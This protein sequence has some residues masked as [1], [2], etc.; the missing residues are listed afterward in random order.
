MRNT[1]LKRSVEILNSFPELQD[2]FSSAEKQLKSPGCTSCRRRKIER[3][4]IQKLSDLI[5]R[6]SE[7]QRREIFSK[8]PF[9]EALLKKAPESPKPPNTSKY[10][11]EDNTR[12]SCLE[13]VLKHTAQAYVLMKES[14]QGYV[15]HVEKADQHL[16]KALR[17]VE[18]SRKGKLEE[19]RNLL[20][21]SL[22]G[23]SPCIWHL[24]RAEGLLLA[25]AQ[26]NFPE[27]SLN[28]WKAVG[29]LGEAADEIVMEYPEFAAEIREERLSVMADSSYEIPFLH[30]LNKARSLLESR[31]GEE[32]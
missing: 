6:K 28:K 2:F 31:R 18:G 15:E 10:L 1:I 14:L 5:S 29:H 8:L 16:D 7:D 9:L 23:L 26:E 32:E 24:S 19:A 25:F 17:Y 12:K 27:I 22:N 3:R 13:C 11:D 20:K 21:E 4:L 30:L